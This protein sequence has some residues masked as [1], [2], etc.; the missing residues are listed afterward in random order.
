M[1]S[2]AKSAGLILLTLTTSTNNCGAEI[3]RREAE[4]GEYCGAKAL[5]V[6]ITSLN[7]AEVKFSEL[8]ANLGRPQRGGYSFAELKDAA[9]SY[10]LSC[11]SV[12]TDQEVLKR[13]CLEPGVH[14]V[15]RINKDHFVTVAAYQNGE[16]ELSDVPDVKTVDPSA[17]AEIWDGEALLIASKADALARSLGGS[18]RSAFFYTLLLAGVGVGV[19]LCF[20]AAAFR[21]FTTPSIGAIVLWGSF[22]GCDNDRREVTSVALAHQHVL[23]ATPRISLESGISRTY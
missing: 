10:G 1:N 16:F 8:L 4:R 2:L 3:S 20:R 5:F 15:I 18:S 14:S 6:V 12:W 23:C 21:K 11:E 9:L 17:L 13:A 19:A 22:V 7:G